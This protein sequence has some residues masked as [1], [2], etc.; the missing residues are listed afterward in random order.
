MAV[1]EDATPAADHTHAPAAAAPGNGGAEEATAAAAHPAAPPAA[2]AAA[3]QTE[4]SAADR[5][6]SKASLQRYRKVSWASGSST[7]SSGCQ[8]I[9]HH[10]APQPLNAHGCPVTWVFRLWQALPRGGRLLGT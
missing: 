5:G 2:A 1:G 8:P 9:R 4:G 3:A 10:D 7:Q 6:S